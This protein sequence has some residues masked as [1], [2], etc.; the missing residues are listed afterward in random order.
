MLTAASACLSVAQL[1]STVS[2]SNG[3]EIKVV[4]SLGKPTGEETLRVEMKRAS[5]DSF[6][7]IFKD[8]NNLVV[9]A[10]ELAVSRSTDGNE[11]HFIAKPVEADFAA[12]FPNADAGKPVPSLS[13]EHEFKALRSGEADGIGLFEIPG[14]GLTVADNIQVVRASDNPA[15]SAG[16]FQFVGLKVSINGAAALGPAP[17]SVTGRYGMFY[18]PG[19]GGYFFSTD[20][21]EGLTFVK[22]GSIDGKVMKFTVDNTSYECT[23]KQPILVHSESGE[24]WVYHDPA[25]KPTGNWTQDKPTQ[26]ATEFF[27]A[28]SDSLNWWLP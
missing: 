27:T 7:R 17:G 16:S 15:A 20:S 1:A 4:A 9:F 14:M 11:F 23:A 10:Y 22:A 5:G 8:Q 12:K 28:A 2:V 21:P 25:Y 24:L 6:Y 3:V 18:I 13:S 26:A 19:K